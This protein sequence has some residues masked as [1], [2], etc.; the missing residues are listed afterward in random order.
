MGGVN[1][2]STDETVVLVTGDLWNV[3]MQVVPHIK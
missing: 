1:P 2:E 3:I